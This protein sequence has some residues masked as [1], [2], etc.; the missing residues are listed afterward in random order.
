M[1]HVVALSL[2]ELISDHKVLNANS[3]GDLFMIFSLVEKSLSSKHA[4]FLEFL[5]PLKCFL[6]LFS[7]A[8]NQFKSDPGSF[9]RNFKHLQFSEILF[10]T[11]VFERVSSSDNP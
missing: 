8:A 1:E 10:V 4:D 2:S 5:F 7:V 3:A 9:L 11:N 6:E